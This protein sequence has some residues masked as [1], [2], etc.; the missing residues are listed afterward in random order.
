MPQKS[1]QRAAIAESNRLHPVL[2][3]MAR[4]QKFGVPSTASL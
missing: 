4:R 3:I 2:D 1:I